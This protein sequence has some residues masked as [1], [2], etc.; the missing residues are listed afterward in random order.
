MLAFTLRRILV[1][2]AVA[3]TVSVASFM[4]LHISGDLATA[5]AGPEA[6]GPQIVQIRKDYGLDQPLLAQ[7]LAW[8]WRALHL[9]FGNS[10]Y[11]RERVIDLLSARLS[12]VFVDEP[13]TAAVL[14]GP[15]DLPTTL[16]D[17]DRLFTPTRE[18]A[19]GRKPRRGVLPQV[20]LVGALVVLALGQIAFKRTEGKFAQEL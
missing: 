7:F 8:A 16:T 4:L 10:F 19:A 9:D 14:P 1:A 17:P 15:A 2:L 6:T 18:R 20:G 3:F 11:F 5:I 13:G 12:G